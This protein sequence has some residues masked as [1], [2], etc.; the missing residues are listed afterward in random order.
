AERLSLTP[1]NEQTFSSKSLL[2]RAR[3][4]QRP[5][6]DAEDMESC[7]GSAEARLAAMVDQ[8][9]AAKFETYKALRRKQG[10]EVIYERFEDQ[11]ADLQR[12]NYAQAEHVPTKVHAVGYLLVSKDQPGEFQEVRSFGA[13]Q[14]ELLARLEHD[15]W[16]QERLEAGWVLD[17]ESSAGNP[18]KKTS[19]YL[20]PYDELSD[21]IKEY[22]RDAVRQLIPLFQRAGLKV[23][24]PRPQ[25]LR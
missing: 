22:D 3:S 19:P 15:R 23:V 7:M 2:A 11:P 1:V 13:E 4:Y 5:Y 18:E 20:V 25:T 21:E 6:L 14:V 17:R 9:V 12:S 24:R 10:L 16:M 8:L